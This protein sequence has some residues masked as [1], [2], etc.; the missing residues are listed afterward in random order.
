MAKFFSAR[1]H[2]RFRLEFKIRYPADIDIK[3]YKSKFWIYLPPSIQNSKQFETSWFQNR[4]IHT[5]FQAPQISIHSL[6]DNKTSSPLFMLR[7]LTHFEYTDGFKAEEER[8]IRHHARLLSCSIKRA[9]FATTKAIEHAETQE[10][11]SQIILEFYQ[12]IKT[13]SKQWLE[14]KRIFLNSQITNKTIQSLHW[15]DEAMGNQLQLVVQDILLNLKEGTV[16]RSKLIKWIHQNRKRIQKISPH[17]LKTSSQ[18]LLRASAL[19]KYTYSAL[20]LKGVAQIEKDWLQHLALGVAA[21]IAMTWA[22]FAQIFAFFQLGI[23][24]NHGMNSTLMVYFFVIAVISYVLKDRIKAT[25]G[26]YLSQRIDNQSRPQVTHYHHEERLNVAIA[27]ERV[28]RITQDQ[29]PDEVQACWEKLQPVPMAMWV[30]GDFVEYER[31]FKIKHQK[32][33]QSVINY[34]G[35]HDIIRYNVADWLNQ[36][37]D[38]QRTMVR[39][40]KNGSMASHDVDRIYEIIMSVEISQN[41]RKRLQHY[42]IHVSQHGLQRIQKVKSLRKQKGKKDTILPKE[43]QITQI[44]QGQ[45]IS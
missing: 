25:A 17:Y 29:L 23:D 37:D 5:R 24:L 19:K 3:E 10:E 28:Q 26:R 11:Q 45:A 30:G 15:A 22:V 42:R 2:D 8:M 1:I 16:G 18:Y 35:I 34:S 27:S 36:F 41:D 31:T 38:A 13:L 9:F 6:L 12:Q 7:S 39:F 40:D 33:E 44:K 21:G 20:F 32:A 14:L 43:N 4:K